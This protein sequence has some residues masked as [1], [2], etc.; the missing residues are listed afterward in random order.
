[1]SRVLPTCAWLHSGNPNLSFKLVAISVSGDKYAYCMHIRLWR[2]LFVCWCCFPWLW[3]Y[4]VVC[5]MFS[6]VLSYWSVVCCMFSVVP[7]FSYVVW[8]VFSFVL[9]IC[10]LIRVFLGPVSLRFNSCYV[11][12]WFDSCCPWSCYIGLWFDSCYPLS[13]YAC[14]WFDS[15]FRG[16]VR[17]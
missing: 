14:L 4:S 8:F 7:T 13:C 10:G 11:G 16:L 15:H 9:L 12:L 3:C 6:M 2:P 1:M 17:L 5:C